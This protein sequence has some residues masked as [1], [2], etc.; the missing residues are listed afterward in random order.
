DANH[1]VVDAVHD[2]ATW[3][4]TGVVGLFGAIAQI[5]F[6]GWV[7]AAALVVGFVLAWRGLPWRITLDRRIGPTAMLAGPLFFF[8]VT[9]VQRGGID[10]DFAK[11]SRYLYVTAAFVLPAIAIAI[12]AL[13]T[14]WRAVGILALLAVLI[15]IPGNIDKAR[16][17]ARQQ[18]FF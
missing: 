12:D 4:R 13:L 5:P 14:R 15:G 18:E 17:F 6:L 9:G 2:L 3:L 16:D 1:S 11:S 10:P 8:V 7:V